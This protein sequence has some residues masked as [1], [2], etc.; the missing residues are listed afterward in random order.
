MVASALPIWPAGRLNY[1]HDYQR[2]HPPKKVIK[3]RRISHWTSPPSGRLKINIDGSFRLDKAAGGIGVVVRNS[4]GRCQASFARYLPKASSALHVELEACRAGLLIAINQ[5]WS[6]IEVES[7]CMQLVNAL[8]NPNED[9]SEVGRIVEDC[10]SYMMAFNFI[11]VRHI[12]REANCVAHRLAHIATFSALDEF[13]LQE[14]PSI[15][16][17]V[18]FEDFYNCTRGSGFTS[19][20]MYNLIHP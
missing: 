5:G 1:L 9:W 3:K 18:L 6:D 11:L 13:W 16:E 17:D 20:S 2:I 19:P 8:N 14:T 15:I 4:Q 12:F 7:D 10:K